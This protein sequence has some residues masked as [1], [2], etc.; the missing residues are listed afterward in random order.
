MKNILVL[1]KNANNII[2]KYFESGGLR[3][4]LFHRLV[5]FDR[6]NIEW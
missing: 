4:I 1:E 5:I 6:K 3:E 2:K